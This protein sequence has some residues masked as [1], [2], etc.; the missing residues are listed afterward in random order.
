MEEVDE[1]LG[2]RRTLAAE[3]ILGPV[4]TEGRGGKIERKGCILVLIRYG[5]QWLKF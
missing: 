3:E 5:R 4:M 1:R 2:G